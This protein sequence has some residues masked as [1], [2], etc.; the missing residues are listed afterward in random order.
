[1][2]WWTWTILV[3]VSLAVLGWLTWRLFVAVKNLLIALGDVSAEAGEAGAAADRQQ[4]I[5]L[6]MRAAQDE[7]YAAQLAE[8]ARPVPR[9][10][11]P[12]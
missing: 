3:L 7:A 12:R 9:G 5:W 2:W 1:M 6:R 10:A 11:L 4:Q 8:H